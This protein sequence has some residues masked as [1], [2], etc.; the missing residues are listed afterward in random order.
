MKGTRFLEGNTQVDEHRGCVGIMREGQE[1][2]KGLRSVTVT[3]SP[4]SSDS[5]SKVN[6]CF[7]PGKQENDEKA[8]S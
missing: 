3:F 4:D 2:V 1:W 8:Y 7:Q 5:N 6:Q